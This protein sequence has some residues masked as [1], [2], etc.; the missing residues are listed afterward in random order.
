M[1]KAAAIHHSRDLRF[2][3]LKSLGIL[4][5]ILAHTIS[6][7]ENPILFQIR[8]FDVP[9]MVLISGALFYIQCKNKQYSFWPYIQKRIPRLIIPVWVF[10]AFFLLFNFFWSR[11]IGESFPFSLE[12]I[13]KIFLLIGGY[14]YIW[15]IRVFVLISLISPLL[16]KLRHALPKTSHFLGVLALTYIAYE[17]LIRFFRFFPI[18]SLS[19]YGLP[20]VWLKLVELLMQDFVLMIIPYGCIFGLGM[21]MST[22]KINKVLLM[23]IFWG[24]VFIVLAFYYWKSLGHFV[25]TQHYKYPPRLYYFSYSIF[26]TSLLYSLT[27][28][29]QQLLKIPARQIFVDGIVFISSSSMWI[30]LWHIFFLNFWRPLLSAVGLDNFGMHEFFIVTILSILMTYFQK[31]IVSRVIRLNQ[32][33]AKA[34]NALTV[35]FLK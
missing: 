10:F 29:N 22:M 31:E 5:I 17:G 24:T 3:I 35:V 12:R 20:E 27:S 33:G 6:R 28:S 25:P 8:N 4:C 21:V 34:S 15:I 7:E 19:E 2:D 18:N 23:S 14:G 30:Y 9:M 11:W 1:N 13:V 32:I 26:I 16:L